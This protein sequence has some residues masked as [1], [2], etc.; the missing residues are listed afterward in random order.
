MASVEGLLVSKFQADVPF[1]KGLE[2]VLVLGP[3]FSPCYKNVSSSPQLRPERSATKTWNEQD[4]PLRRVGTLTLNRNV[5]NYH[6]EVEQVAF[7]PSNLP[8]G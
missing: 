3:R 1:L 5:N 4:F 7:A 8:P 6:N 2:R